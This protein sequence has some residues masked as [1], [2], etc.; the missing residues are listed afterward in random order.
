MCNPACAASTASSSAPW[1]EAGGIWRG[2]D[3][4]P[5]AASFNLAKSRR[6]AASPNQPNRNTSRNLGLIAMKRPTLFLFL[7]LATGLVG[8]AATTHPETAATSHFLAPGIIDP[9][10][11][12][13]PPPAP[14]SLVQHAEIEVLL[15]L[16][17]A[18]T[19]AQVARARQV[20]AEDVFVFGS[21]VLG[22]W[23]NAANLPQTAAFFARVSIDFV[24]LNHA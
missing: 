20:Q 2:A 15:N 8:H 16:Q 18:R 21:D 3:S 4:A 1:N 24:P 22:E 23:F 14:D 12:I 13:P 17:A 6:K 19:P 9:Q 11:L 5:R 10:S 7:C